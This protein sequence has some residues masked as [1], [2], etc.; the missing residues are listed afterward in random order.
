M[1]IYPT[2]LGATP[3]A[4]RASMRQLHDSV[5]DVPGVQAASLSAG[6]M[7]LSGDSELPFWIEGQPK[8]ATES[9]M[10]SA[11]FYGVEPDFL[12]AM[13]IPLVRGRFLTPAEAA[14]VAASTRRTAR[15][16]PR[17][18]H[19][20]PAF[21]TAFQ[22]SSGDL[23]GSAAGDFDISRPIPKHNRLSPKSG[24]S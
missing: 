13:G 5:A 8:P 17:A 6:S 22:R 24:A 15:E 9:E 1:L 19:R 18:T 11:L 4:I 21:R 10:K 12:K 7:P 20:H 16:F 3:D 23:V 14:K 2:A